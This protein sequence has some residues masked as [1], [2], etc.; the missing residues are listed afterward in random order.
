MRDLLHTYFQ[1]VETL[2]QELETAFQEG[3]KEYLFGTHVEH[4][5]EF[6]PLMTVHVFC[7]SHICVSFAKMRRAAVAQEGEGQHR[8]TARQWAVST[9]DSVSPLVTSVPHIQNILFR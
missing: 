3:R 6:L 9:C 8:W 5:E 1:A 2:H 7:V 4:V